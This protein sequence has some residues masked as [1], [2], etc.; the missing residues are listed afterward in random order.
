MLYIFTDS[1]RAKQTS[2]VLAGI[3]FGCGGSGRENM[4]GNRQNSGF[5][6]R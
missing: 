2:L 1:A 3:S 4:K 6:V 5:V